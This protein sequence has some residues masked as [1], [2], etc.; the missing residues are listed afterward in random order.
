MSVV[1]DKSEKLPSEWSQVKLGDVLQVIRGASPRPKG[2]PRYFGGDI[3]WIKISDITKEKGK[4]IST[5]KD[6]VTEEGAQKSRY[7]KA[8]TL[9]LSNSGTVCVPKILGTGVGPR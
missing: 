2:D 5:T 9:I 4:Y 7:L 1:Q 6:Y 8:G 3:P